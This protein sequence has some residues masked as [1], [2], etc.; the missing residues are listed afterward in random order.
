ML[1]V[2]LS[3]CGLSRHSSW[4]FQ[5]CRLRRQGSRHFRQPAICGI[6]LL[7]GLFL[8]G[9]G[10]NG[11]VEPRPV[12]MIQYFLCYPEFSISG[13]DRMAPWSRDDAAIPGCF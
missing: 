10:R 6:F 3:L 4:E 9:S 5:D 13:A 8:S 2:Y 7:P 12:A 11:S 1:T